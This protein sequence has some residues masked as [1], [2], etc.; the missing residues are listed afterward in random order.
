MK[1]KIRR[2]SIVA[3][4]GIVSFG[5]YAFV[6]SASHSWGGY[7]WA[8]T[9]NPFSLKLG[10]DVSSVWGPYLGLA[11]NDWSISGVLD[12]VVVSGST[13]PKSCKPASGRVEVCNSKYGATGWLGVAQIWVS[14]SNITQG[15]VKLNDTYFST[16]K[17]NTPAWREFVVCQEAGHTLGLAHQ[18]ESFNNP[19][20][21][22]CLDYTNDPDG[23]TYNQLS[24]LRPNQHDY[25]E[26]DLIYAHLD[27]STTV[28][29]T[30]ARGSQ[31]IDLSDPSAWGREIRRSADGS[32][33]LFERDF[34]EGNK[35]FT[36]VI[37]AL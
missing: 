12:T 5:A 26:L 23:M 19:N 24:N 18:D 2:A 1:T 4:V 17:Y 15:T 34:G 29:Q 21:G 30:T 36:F 16:A 33:S 8:R 10:S 27:T 9:S 32:P 35:V 3:A 7:H 31:N 37:W 11:S 14:G 22:S 6:A 20:L 25:D 28:G 13:N